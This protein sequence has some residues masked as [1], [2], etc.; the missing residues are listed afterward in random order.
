MAFSPPLNRGAALLELNPQ[1]TYRE[2]G[3]VVLPGH[4]PRDSK[5][6]G[7]DAPEGRLH[8]VYHNARHRGV[9]FNPGVGPMELDVRDLWTGTVT[10]GTAVVYLA[11]LGKARASGL[12]ETIEGPVAT[13]PK[14][15]SSATIAKA[16]IR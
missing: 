14:P 15:L 9:C 11:G 10:S 3:G 2:T 7:N 8:F 6:L 4:Q 12:P 1:E 13:W 16:G 5:H